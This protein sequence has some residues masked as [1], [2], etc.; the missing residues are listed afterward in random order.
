VSIDT[1][2]KTFGIGA[3]DVDRDE[4]KG[5]Q[6]VNSAAHRTPQR[7]ADPARGAKKGPVRH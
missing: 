5:T 7:L 1:L 3:F 2:A 4:E 6:Q